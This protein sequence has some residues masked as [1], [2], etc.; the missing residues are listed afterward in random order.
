MEQP[1]SKN[2]QLGSAAEAARHTLAELQRE[3]TRLMR[4]MAAITESMHMLQGVVDA[5]ERLNPER[6][7]LAKELVRIDQELRS[8][9]AAE[10]GAAAWAAYRPGALG[11]GGLDSVGPVGPGALVQGMGPGQRSPPGLAQALALSRRAAMA[12][13]AAGPPLVRRPVPAPA[14]PAASPA[15][16]RSGASAVSSARASPA[17]ASAPAIGS[18]LQAASHAAPGNK[19]A[20]PWAAG[21]EIVDRVHGVLAA[22][23]PMAPGEVLAAIIERYKVRYSLGVIALAMRYGAELGKYRYDGGTGRYQL[24]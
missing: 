9:N 24:A 22:G 11:P 21:A 23:T 6:D 8:L 7:P 20:G 10:E 4:R 16:S 1:L 12:R 17:A 5:W 19:P 13:L 15:A 18:D 2:P 3:Y 14:S